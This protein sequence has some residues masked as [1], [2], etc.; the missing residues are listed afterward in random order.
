MNVFTL[1]AYAALC[2]PCLFTLLSQSILTIIQTLYLSRHNVIVKTLTV[3]Q[4][5]RFLVDE[6]KRQLCTANCSMLFPRYHKGDAYSSYHATH[7]VRIQISQNCNQLMVM[8]KITIIVSDVSICDICTC[9]GCDDISTGFSC[10]CR[11]SLIL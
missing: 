1:L 5:R 3:F 11:S 8:D 10:D 4:S 6:I 2:S 7:T 9:F